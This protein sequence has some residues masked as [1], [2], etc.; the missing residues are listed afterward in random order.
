M[1]VFNE[2]VDQ[3]ELFVALPVAEDVKIN[4]VEV[5]VRV[6]TIIQTPTAIMIRS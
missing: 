6:S 2:D 4:F 5:S 3:L 1:S